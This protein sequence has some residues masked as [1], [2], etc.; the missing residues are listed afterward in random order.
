[1]PISDDDLFSAHGVSAR[2]LDTTNEKMKK[3]EGMQGY[4]KLTEVARLISINGKMITTSKIVYIAKKDDTLF[5]KTRNSIYTFLL[6]V[7]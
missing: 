1:M 2:L 3:C 5:V 7:I 6:N 4:L